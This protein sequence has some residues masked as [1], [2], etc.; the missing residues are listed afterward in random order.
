MAA[1]ADTSGF[2]RVIHALRGVLPAAADE[3]LKTT[4]TAACRDI[5]E[6]CPVNTHRMKRGFQMGANEAGLGPFS[7][8]AVQPSRF[9]PSTNRTLKK[10]LNRL[11]GFQTYLA[12][13]GEQNGKE[14]KKLTKD[15]ER[16]K[17]EI[18]KLTSTSILIINKGRRIEY[19]VRSK[20]Y[21]GTG[22][23]EKTSGGYRVTVR[24][25]EP[26]AIIR[27]RAGALVA[28][29]LAKTEA[30]DG[31]IRARSAM[32]RKFRAAA[33]AGVVR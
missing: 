9:L 21:G 13:V 23:F 2:S 25:L 30:Y 14:Y 26:H 16:A 6:Q 20:I 33:G 11:V 17:Q 32:L 27:E 15:I 19:T 10:Q 5:I 3:A 8:D 29:V 12:S 28:T 24:N 7:V 18:E 22:K 4:M 31:R 1:R